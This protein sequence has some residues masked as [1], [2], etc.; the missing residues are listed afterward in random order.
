MA[1]GRRERK[2]AERR[3]KAAH[4]PTHKT[5]EGF[6]VAARPS[7]NKMLLCELARC[8]YIDRR[9]NVLLVGSPGT[10]KTHCETLF[11]DS[12]RLSS[13]IPLRGVV[14]GAVVATASMTRKTHWHGTW[15]SERARQ[16][17]LPDH[18]G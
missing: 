5:L 10:G 16:Q 12:V 3:L 14:V 15:R 2:A 17:P 18:R 13:A 6:D 11:C 1:T 7:V 9:E 4:F 8:E